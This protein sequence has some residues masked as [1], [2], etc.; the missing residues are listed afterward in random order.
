MHIHGGTFSHHTCLLA[1]TN[2]PLG[3]QGPCVWWYQSPNAGSAQ[4]A[5]SPTA[6]HTPK[7]LTWL[8]WKCAA[9]SLPASKPALPFTL[10]RATSRS[11]AG[12]APLPSLPSAPACDCWQQDWAS[13]ARRNPQPELSWAGG[14]PLVNETELRSS[15]CQPPLHCLW[16]VGVAHQ[17][18]PAEFICTPSLWVSENRQLRRRARLLQLEM[19]PPSFQEL[20]ELKNK[21]LSL[22]PLT[23][24]KFAN[25][26][27]VPP[28][29]Y[30]KTT[31]AC[32]LQVLRRRREHKSQR[33]P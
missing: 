16:R 9:A 2:P 13:V 28:R 12:A 24:L 20:C 27:R 21:V 23:W 32:F 14:T 31:S 10:K 33:A 17:L 30:H 6:R 19:P 18:L 22:K 15:D 26:P 1:E 3:N 4:S 5:L 7:A 11:S 29:E 25:I 8:G